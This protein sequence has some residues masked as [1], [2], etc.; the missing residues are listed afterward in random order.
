[1]DELVS[2]FF[3]SIC[4]SLSDAKALLRIHILYYM[5]LWLRFIRRIVAFEGIDDV[6][7]I[8]L[9]HIGTDA[10]VKPKSI[11]ICK[12]IFSFL[13]LWNFY[14]GQKSIIHVDR[15]TQNENWD[16]ICWSSMRCHHTHTHT[17]VADSTVGSRPSMW[18]CSRPSTCAGRCQW[19]LL[20]CMVCWRVI[21]LKEN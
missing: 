1:M 6:N 10:L 17:L 4:L 13:F 8:Y 21:D 5:C 7:I 2:P 15:S 11:S 3:L 9:I 14:C 20:R 18:S 16:V 19:S 12:V